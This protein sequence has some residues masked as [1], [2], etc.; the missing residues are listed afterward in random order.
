M[1]PEH[2]W[3]PTPCTT[4]FETLLFID[5]DVGFELVDALRILARPE[6]VVAG[7][8]PKKGER[9]PDQPVRPGIERG[10]LRADRPGT[11]PAADTPPPASCESRP[12]SCGE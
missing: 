3:L 9:S 4:D 11:V 12:M 1:C 10:P 8:Y 2:P 6:P 7:V 5:A